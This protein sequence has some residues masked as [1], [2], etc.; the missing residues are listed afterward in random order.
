MYVF[1]T[2]TSDKSKELSCH[3][4]HIGANIT[5]LYSIQIRLYRQGELSVSLAYNKHWSGFQCLHSH[6]KKGLQNFPVSRLKSSNAYYGYD[7]HKLQ[8]GQEVWSRR[9]KLVWKL[10]EQECSQ[11][12]IS[13]NTVLDFILLLHWH[14]QQHLFSCWRQRVKSC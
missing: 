7:A 5:C 10:H 9:Y 11:F 1:V 13:L 4:E 14:S 6:Y 8:D 12:S 3:L 2:T